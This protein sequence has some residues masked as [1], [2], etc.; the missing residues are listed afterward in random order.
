MYSGKAVGLRAADSEGVTNA[1]M[2]VIQI[3]GDG[4]CERR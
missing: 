3:E 1:K 4:W 2:P